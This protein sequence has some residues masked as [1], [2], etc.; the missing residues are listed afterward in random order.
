MKRVSGFFFF[1]YC[2]FRFAFINS[3][4]LLV[5]HFL[6]SLP[7]K[8][9]SSGKKSKNYCSVF[10]C[11]AYYSLDEN[12]SYHGLPSANGPKVLWKNG[13]G[14]EELVNCQTIWASILR[15]SKKT[16]NKKSIKVCSKHFTVNDYFR[17]SNVQRV[18]F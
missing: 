6:F 12:I 7:R 10:G 8:M 2:L 13:D 4:R 11:T 3:S 14:F 15:L 17:P 16:L 1:F 5:K 9:S 18:F